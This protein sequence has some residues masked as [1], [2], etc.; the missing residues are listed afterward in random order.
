MVPGALI[1]DWGREIS[2]VAFG[3]DGG[4]SGE[5]ALGQVLE[6]APPDFGWAEGKE[7]AEG[8]EGVRGEG[9]Q[10]SYF[11]GDGSGRPVLGLQL[12]TKGGVSHFLAELGGSKADVGGDGE[13]DEGDLSQAVVDKD[14]VG[15]WSESVHSR[16]RRW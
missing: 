6:E 16:G 1:G 11:S 9:P 10:G 2:A 13:L 15:R 8:G 4:R 3:E 5:G 12:D 14:E 7:G